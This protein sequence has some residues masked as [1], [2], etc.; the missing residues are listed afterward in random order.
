[1]TSYINVVFRPRKTYDNNCRS[2]TFM[3]TRIMYFKRDPCQTRE[4]VVYVKSLV[5]LVQ[6]RM[7]AI[8]P[9]FR[10][11][12]SCPLLSLSLLSLGLLNCFLFRNWSSAFNNNAVGVKLASDYRL[13]LS[14][15]RH[16]VSG[17]NAFE[18]KTFFTRRPAVVEINFFCSFCFDGFRKRR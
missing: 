1:M 6:N 5:E 15:F 17:T 8:S 12:W 4:T 3:E 2:S 7:H 18:T 9:A 14:T 16:D 13:S 11:E 10:W